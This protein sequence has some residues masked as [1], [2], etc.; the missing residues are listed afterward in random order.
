MTDAEFLR[1]CAANEPMRFERD[2][3][4]EIIV[5]SPTGFEGSGIESEVFTELAVWTRAD[6]R[7]K[8]FG[9]TAGFKLRDTSVRAAD[10]AWVSWRQVNSVDPAEAKGFPSI[11]PEFVIEVRSQS[12]KLAE[13]KAKM[14][15]WIANGAEVA[16]L[17]DP[18]DRV[19]TVYRPGSE[20]ECHHNP[21]SVQGTGPIAGFELVLARVWG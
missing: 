16:W 15:E 21:S 4:G 20:P 2:A 6:G 18:I 1:F 13:L 11:C 5:M 14:E 9:P 12:D 7:G 17:I 19:V 3:N 8:A 10:A